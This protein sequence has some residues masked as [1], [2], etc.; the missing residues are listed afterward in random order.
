[1][2]SLD[3]G[4]NNVGNDSFSQHAN[5]LFL[6]AVENSIGICREAL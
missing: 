5:K 4:E 2:L 3:I 6:F 1:M